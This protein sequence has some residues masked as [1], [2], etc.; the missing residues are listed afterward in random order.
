MPLDREARSRGGKRVGEIYSPEYYRA[1]GEAGG[2]ELVR[3]RGPAYMAELGRKSGA[4]RRA[5]REQLQAEKAQAKPGA[6]AGHPASVER[7]Q[8]VEKGRQI[9]T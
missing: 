9:F 1:L 8:Q 6:P 5:K 2:L 7:E 4:S 3:K